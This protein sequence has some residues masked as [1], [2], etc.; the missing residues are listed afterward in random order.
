MSYGADKCA[1]TDG[2]N[3]NT[4]G[5]VQKLTSGKKEACVTMLF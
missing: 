2:S 4:G 5:G 1:Q 3:D